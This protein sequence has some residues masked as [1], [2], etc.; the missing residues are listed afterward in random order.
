MFACGAL[1]VALLVQFT[2]PFGQAL[3]E[4]SP[5]SPRRPRPVSA[6]VI[7]DYPAILQAPVFAPDRQ[8]GSDQDAASAGGPLGG[9]VAIGVAIGPKFAAALLKGPDGFIRT[10][11]RGDRVQDWRLV[12]IESSQITFARDTARH[13]IAVGAPAASAAPTTATATANDN[14]S[15]S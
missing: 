14:G 11:H 12:A 7:P 9:F 1:L 13:V 8:P 4:A 6:P 15:D 5:V 3:T 10:L 2:L